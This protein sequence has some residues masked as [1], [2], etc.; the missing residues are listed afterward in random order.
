MNQNETKRAWVMVG[1]DN[2]IRLRDDGGFDWSSKL[3]PGSLY[4]I[5]R[6]VA[7]AIAV[8][9]EMNFLKK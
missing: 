6:D 1:S 4:V 3:H 8:A 2:A 9:F 5:P 7:A